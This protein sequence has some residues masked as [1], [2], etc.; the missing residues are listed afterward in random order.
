MSETLNKKN[1]GWQQ[2][3][4]WLVLA[5]LLCA[6]VYLLFANLGEMAIAD[7]D[8][9][10]HGVNAYEM[11]RN[12]EYIVHTYGGETDYWNLKPPAS[13]W[14]VVLGYRLFGYNALGLRFFSA[15]AS[16][17]S[18][19]LV[20]V[21]CARRYGVWAA[22]MA[23]CAYVCNHGMYVNH[24]SRFGDADAL[25]Q[26]FFT[27]AMLCMLNGRKRFGWFYGSAF[28][29]ALAFLTKASHALNIGLI[30]ALYVLCT[31]KL[32]QLKPLRILGLLACAL[33]PIGLWAA[34]RY[35]KDGT[36]FFEG[37]FLT[38]VV[39]RLGSTAHMDNKTP[40]ALYLEAFWSRPSLVVALIVCALCALACVLLHIRLSDD[41]KDALIGTLLWLVVPIVFYTVTKTKFIW[42]VYSGFA[43]ICVLTAIL[44]HAVIA[45]GH[46]KGI[47]TAVLALA[48]AAMCVFGWQNVQRISTI[49]QEDTY[50]LV[51][52]E[53]LDRDMDE[54]THIYIQYNA[55]VQ[56][57]WNPMEWMQA[58]RLTAMLYGDTVCM[59]GGVEAFL[60]DEDYAILVIGQSGNQDWIN[61]LYEECYFRTE[62]GSVM[63]V[64]K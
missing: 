31:G 3:C 40:L 21:W 60:A 22:V 41:S 6:A 34:A 4:G 47:R 45:S 12:D 9:A 8:E 50:Q 15:L 23:L 54:G 57:V 61:T 19:A 52:Q 63:I 42:Y 38:D 33:L 28:A 62:E 58:D 59:D 24:F 1:A 48:F 2:L 37:M 18:M 10:R 64:D 39:D 56:N 7:Y 32:P 36:A 27:I 55:E 13:F 14:S 26:L 5:L 49:T 29:F 25:Y 51:M 53:M 46:L 30:C 20:A 11:I 35:A 43:A 44:V 17:V 16:L